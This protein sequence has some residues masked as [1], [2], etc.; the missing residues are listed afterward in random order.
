MLSS[1]IKKKRGMSHHGNVILWMMKISCYCNLFYM[2]HSK[3]LEDKGLSAIIITCLPFEAWKIIFTPWVS[4]FMPPECGSQTKENTQNLF[5]V[6][7]LLT[8]LFLC[9]L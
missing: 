7:E 1:L 8:F 9:P 2:P 6:Y 4:V 5:K 3:D